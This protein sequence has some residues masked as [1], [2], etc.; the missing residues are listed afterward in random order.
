MSMRVISSSLF[1]LGLSLASAHAAA[2]DVYRSACLDTGV[3]MANIRAATVAEAS[4]SSGEWVFVDLGF[5]SQTK[6]CG[7]LVGEDKARALSFAQLQNEI[8]SICAK[9]TAPLNI[10]LEAPLSVAF[11][12]NGNPTGRSVEKRNG[13]TRY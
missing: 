10:L 9:G 8:L 4:R 1:G 6:S 2:F 3:D 11:G 13:Q 5:S 12:P 7:L